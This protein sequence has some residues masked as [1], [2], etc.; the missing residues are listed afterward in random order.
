MRP[1]PPFNSELIYQ[2]TVTE[3]SY[4]NTEFGLN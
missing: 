2:G 3:Q 1:H 4:L